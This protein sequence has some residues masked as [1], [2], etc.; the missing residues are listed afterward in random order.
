MSWS[1]LPSRKRYLW[2]GALVAAAAQVAQPAETAPP[3]GPTLFLQLCAECHGRNGE[4][5][6]SVISIAGPA[7]KAEHDRGAVITAVE[8]GPGHMPSF[9]SVLSV[10]QIQAIADFV[11]GQLAVLPLTGGDLGQGGVL[12]RD[13]CA[14]CHRTAVRGGALVFAGTNAPALTNKS[15]AL[16]AGTIRSGAGPMPAFP[17]S[18]LNDQQVASVVE[19]IRYIQ[20]PPSPGG[21]PLNWYGPVAEGAV[22]WTGM[23]CL[24]GILTWIEKGEKG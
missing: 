16:I 19:Y 15:A 5:I 18:V 9:A 13:Y 12:F 1:R 20:H 2:L 24:I 14:A 11:T 10:E 7:L 8:V 17:P 3:D 21:S 6:S 23:F 22:A 4:G